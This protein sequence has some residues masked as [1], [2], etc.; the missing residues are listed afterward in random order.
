MEPRDVLAARVEA[1]RQDLELAA[2]ALTSKVIREDLL[3]SVN[4]LF[5]G[6]IQ[7]KTEELAA[8]ALTLPNGASTGRGALAPHW[9]RFEQHVDECDRLLRQDFAFIEGALVRS[10]GL[11]NRICDLADEYLRHLASVT[12][13]DWTRMTILADSEFFVPM[14]DIIRMRYPHFSIWNLPVLAHEFGHFVTPRLQDRLGSTDPIKDFRRKIRTQARTGVPPQA[15]DDAEERALKHLDEFIA[16]AFAVYAAGPAY[17]CTC[18]LLRFEPAHAD[19]DG[20]D[21]PSDGRRAYLLLK[22][23]ETLSAD[24]AK[25]GRFL[26]SAWAMNLEAAG[27]AAMRTPDPWL[28]QIATTLAAILGTLAPKARFDAAQWRNAAAV[29]RRLPTDDW[30]KETGGLT[31][32]EITNAAWLCRIANEEASAPVISS[33]ALELFLASTLQRH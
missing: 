15:A 3:K 5:S 10:A 32:N 24:Y 13:V 19:E 7:R 4:V 12:T 22:L 18:L 33:K 9:A 1:F 11:D 2:S 29:S 6:L 17:A 14:T 30:K 21:H 16:D 31:P 28:D 25:V 27:R 8:F 20:P 26:Q 23:L